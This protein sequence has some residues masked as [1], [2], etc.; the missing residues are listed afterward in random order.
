MENKKVKVEKELSFAHLED[1]LKFLNKE[2]YL[3]QLTHIWKNYI[4]VSFRLKNNEKYII[5][6]QDKLI[7]LS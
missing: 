1:H 6:E 3:L 7:E 2:R 4:Y 5:K